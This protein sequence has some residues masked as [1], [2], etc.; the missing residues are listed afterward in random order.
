MTLK[1]RVLAISTRP[2]LE[3]YPRDHKSLL[4]LSQRNLGASVKG[5]VEVYPSEVSA[6]VVCSVVNRYL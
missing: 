2:L 3:Q 5:S 4:C 6:D 1:S